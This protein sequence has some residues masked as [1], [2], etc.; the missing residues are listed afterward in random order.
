MKNKLE[1]P[2]G[3]LCFKNDPDSA[4]VSGDKIEMISLSGNPISHYYWGNCAFDLSGM[5]AKAGKYPILHQHWSDEKVG[6]SGKPVVD[7]NKLKVVDGKFVDTEIAQEVKKLSNEGFPYQASI[8]FEPLVVERFKEKETIELNGTKIKG[9]GTIFRKWIYIESSVCV[10][11]QDSGTS[12]RAFDED[13]KLS[14]EVEEVG[15]INSKEKEVVLVDLK[16]FKKEH[17]DLAKEF[18]AEIAGAFK[19]DQKKLSDKIVDLEK[20][21]SAK[22]GE[23]DSLTALNKTV[24]KLNDRLDSMETEN[25][26]LRKFKDMTEEATLQLTANELVET[27]LSESEIPDRLR[28]KVGGYISPDKFVKDG[29]LDVEGFSA[30][31]DEEIKSWTDQGL[32]SS[33]KGFSASSKTV[34]DNSATQ[35]EKEDEDGAD[36]MLKLAGGAD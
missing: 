30:H 25:K 12:T 10:F 11:G 19:A 3:A 15:N 21:L 18:S 16:Q 17:P 20:K 5:V 24:D 4:S 34:S 9:P 22:E 27:K 28:A 6:F 1:I 26:S 7:G 33:V 8:R 36:F 13:E 14:I 31:I 29:K 35:M 2:K 23:S 32:T